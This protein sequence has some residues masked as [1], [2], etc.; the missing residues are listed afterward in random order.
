MGLDIIRSDTKNKVE[1]NKGQKFVWITEH[2]W[3]LMR[4]FFSHWSRHSVGGSFVVR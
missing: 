2:L 1:G 3:A 4:D